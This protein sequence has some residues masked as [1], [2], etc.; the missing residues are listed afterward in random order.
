MM[1]GR[2]KVTSIIRRH[3]RIRCSYLLPMY[4]PFF[5]QRPMRRKICPKDEKTN[6]FKWKGHL[7]VE[8]AKH[9]VLAV[10]FPSLSNES[11]REDAPFAHVPPFGGVDLRF[12]ALWN[13]RMW[14]ANGHESCL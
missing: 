10:V 9:L 7:H 6:L 8:Y 5:K 13:L 14:V 11:N 12:L 4:F 3:F 2:S 1:H